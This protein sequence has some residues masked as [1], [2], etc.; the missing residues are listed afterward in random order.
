[1]WRS[2]DAVCNVNLVTYVVS[3]RHLR[4]SPATYVIVCKTMKKQMH[5]R[6]EQTAY[7]QSKDLIDKQINSNIAWLH[8]DIVERKKTPNFSLFLLSVIIY[9]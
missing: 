7:D 4:S 5:W 8:D 9:K 2:V 3:G 1:M 6:A